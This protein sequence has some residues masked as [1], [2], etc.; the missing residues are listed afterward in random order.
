MNWLKDT[1]AI[2]DSGEIGNT[3]G[4]PLPLDYFTG[5][6]NTAT[7]ARRFFDQGSKD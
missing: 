6:V 2:R 4:Q 7:Q 1:I 5:H 3:M